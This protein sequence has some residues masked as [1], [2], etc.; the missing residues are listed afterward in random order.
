MHNFF[1]RFT[2]ECFFEL[3]LCALISIAAERTV[4]TG[5]NFSTNEA[6]EAKKAGQADQV[7]S[8]ASCLL[9]TLLVLFVLN[10]LS[11]AW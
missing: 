4:Y 2:Y 1:T 3:F 10:A 9:L 5:D 11:Y 8:I 6:K 7:E